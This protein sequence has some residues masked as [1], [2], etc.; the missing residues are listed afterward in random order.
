MRH[1]DLFEKIKEIKF[2]ERRNKGLNDSLL[3]TPIGKAQD[4]DIS[5]RN[6]S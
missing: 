3:Y 5:R 6:V 4:I 1:T 2:K